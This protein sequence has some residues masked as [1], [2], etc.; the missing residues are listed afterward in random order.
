MKKMNRQTTDLE[1]TFAKHTSDKRICIQHTERTRTKFLFIFLAV[2]SLSFPMF[3]LFRFSHQ[4]S[5]F[6]VLDLYING[7]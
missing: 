5:V 2:Q 3:S 1:E 7:I 6:L 4:S